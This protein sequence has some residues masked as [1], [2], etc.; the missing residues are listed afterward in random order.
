MV[1]PSLS[2]EERQTADRRL[3]AGFVALVGLSGGLVALASGATPVQSLAAVGVGL[4]VG[5]A[6]LVYLARIGRQYGRTRRR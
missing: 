4:L 6:L 3:R 5:G 1:G 2:E